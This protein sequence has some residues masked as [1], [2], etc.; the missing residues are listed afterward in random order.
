LFGLKIMNFVS[1]WH[2]KKI[3]TVVMWRS[4]SAEAHFREGYP[5]LL[6]I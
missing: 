4:G 5:G 3:R 2:G 1:H 6:L